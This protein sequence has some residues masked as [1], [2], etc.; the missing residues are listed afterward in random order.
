MKKS[1]IFGFALMASFAFGQTNIQDARNGAIGQTVTIKGVVTNGSELGPIRY[2]QDATGALPA[3]GTNLNGVQ[4]GDSISATGV[5][6]DFNGLLEISPTTSFVA[7]GVG[8]LP[9]PQILPLTAID[10]TNEAELVRIENVTFVQTG[11]FAAGNSTVQVTDGINTLDVRINGST[12][13][14]GTSIPTGPVTIIALVGQFNANYQ[15]VPRDLNDIIAYVAPAQEINIK[16]AGMNVVD[17]G[18]YVIG[19]NPATTVTVENSGTGTLNVSGITFSGANAAEFSTPATTINVGPMSSQTFTINFA[20]AGPGSRTA[21]MQIASNDADENPYDITL[22]AIGTNGLATEPTANPSAL[23]FSNVQAYTVTGTFTAAANTEKYI[24]LWKNGSAITGAP[25][26]GTNYRRGDIVGDARVAFIGAGT[27]FIPRGVIANQTYHFAVYSFNGPAGFENYQTTAPLTGTVTSGG[28]NIGNYY[29]GISSASSD[30]VSDLTAKINPHTVVSYANYRTT[31]MFQ[32]EVKDTT[33]GQSYV[34]C[35]YS[36]EKKVFDDPFEWSP[37]GY[38]REHTYA[39]SWMPSFPADGTPGKPEY[40]DQHNLF[41]T[42]LA[43]ANSIRS[44][45]PLGEI[46]GDVVYTYLE[47]QAGNGP[48][49]QLVYQPRPSHRGNAAR[50]IMYMAVAYDGISGNDWQIPVGQSQAILKEWHEADAPDNYEIARHEYIFSQ[51]N[52]RN[53][54]IDS[55]QFACFID[56]SNSLNYLTEGCLSSGVGLDDLLNSAFV[57]FPVPAQ[58]EVYLQVNTTTISAYSIVDMQGRLLKSETVDNLPLVKLA[59]DT[60]QAGSYIVKV[61]TPFG[62]VK[63]SLIIE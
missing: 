19:T 52:N 18:S 23:T 54:F 41:P 12:N 32:F 21:L 60:M 16:I 13:I 6:F 10:E 17:G 51:Q 48:G 3:Y 42:N 61:Q 55:V 37:N 14:D 25:V 30:L 56:F 50:A 44:N 11:M 49:G 7:H 4:R 62:E 20:A 8:T 33:A 38:S 27:S 47:G 58:N 59:T 57:V 28:S 34:T 22:N 43:Q 9:T 15:L 1:I 36:G 39:H 35:A 5:L 45:L 53:P 31:V 46:T 29:A 40:S 24:V 2:I 63:R 26:D